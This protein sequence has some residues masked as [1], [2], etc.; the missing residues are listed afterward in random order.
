[1]VELRDPVVGL[2]LGDCGGS[3]STGSHRL[4]GDTLTE[5][6]T[7]SDSVD[8]TRDRSWID[9]TG[10]QLITMTQIAE[11]LRIQSSGLQDLL[12]HDEESVGRS[13]EW[14]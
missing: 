3:T 7:T 6:G 2:V 11:D 10:N 9:N 13:H 14:Q 1:M 12:L 5:T 8:V 4:V